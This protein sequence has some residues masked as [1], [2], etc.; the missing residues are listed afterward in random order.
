MIKEGPV[1]VLLH[2]LVDYAVGVLLVLGPFLVAFDS[3]GATA[4]AILIGL[5]ALAM[6]VLT[7]APFGVLRRMPLAAHL[8]LD[9]VL[10]ILLIVLPFLASFTEDRRA[11]ALFVILGVGHLIVSTLTRFD[12]GRR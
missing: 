10:A 1:P 8:V 11:F 7:D 4:V 5:A 12:L 9:Y 3:G 6:A 2:G